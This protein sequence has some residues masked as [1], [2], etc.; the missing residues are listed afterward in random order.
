MHETTLTGLRNQ[1]CYFFDLV[2]FGETVRVLRNGKPIAE[3][4]TLQPHLPSWKQRVARPLC[5]DGVEIS[6]MSLDD[7][8]PDVSISL[9]LAR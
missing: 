3:I 9:L 2:E 7:R 1:P 8:G 6:R 5:V 4:L